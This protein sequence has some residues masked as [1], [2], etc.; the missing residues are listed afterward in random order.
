[1]SDNSPEDEADLVAAAQRDRA[2]FPPKQWSDGS[3]IGPVD[4]QSDPEGQGGFVLVI[5][6]S[7]G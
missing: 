1:V 2:A 5:E 3:I 6:P 4:P 7:M